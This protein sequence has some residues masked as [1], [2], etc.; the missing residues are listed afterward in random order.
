MCLA[1]P[2]LAHWRTFAG[3]YCRVDDDA[4]VCSPHCTNHALYATL[5]R[6]LYCCST[7]K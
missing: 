2:G 4:P 5:Y 3:R 1:Q 6:F 7:S